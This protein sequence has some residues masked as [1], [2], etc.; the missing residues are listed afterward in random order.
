[1][2][3]YIHLTWI[4][5]L[6]L[7]LGGCNTDTSM[8]EENATKTA[9]EETVPLPWELAEEQDFSAVEGFWREEGYATVYDITIYPNG[10]FLLHENEEQF[11]GYLVYT[12]EDGD[13]LWETGPRYEM[14]LENNEQLYGDAY[15][16]LDENH[17]GKLSYCVGGGAVL[18]TRDLPVMANWPAD[19]YLS[20][21]DGFI[22]DASDA[23]T[24][25]VFSA[26]K[27]LKDFQVL[28]LS[29]QETDGEITFSTVVLYTQDSL[30]PQRPLVVNM[31]FFGTM[32]NNG[33]SFVDTNG[34]TKR[35]TVNISG[36]DGSLELQAF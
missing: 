36:K 14:Y 19:T 13:G 28:A 34:Q 6:A 21:Y 26:A 18:F 35:F 25:V 11:D 8:P 16:A 27:E 3:K 12:E 5:T 9:T 10:G 22:A 30:T 24:Q 23:A 1:M 7:L 15:L 2:K 32:P 33:I 29:P 4:L 20:A 31:A 17:P